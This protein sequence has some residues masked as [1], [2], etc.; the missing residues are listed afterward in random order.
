MEEEETEGMINSKI[1]R[2]IIKNARCIAREGIK[3]F[4]SP[5]LSHFLFRIFVP[6]SIFFFFF[7][8]MNVTCTTDIRGGYNI[9]KIRLVKRRL[10]LHPRNVSHI[11]TS[12]FVRNG[13]VYRFLKI[14]NL[15]RSFKC[16]VQSWS[17]FHDKL[18]MI[19]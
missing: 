18:K 15:S 9:W 7:W 16:T 4:L 12:P 3:Y 19:G 8:E 10:D 11:W 6:I 14:R 1:F 17:T 2:C 13:I 5:L